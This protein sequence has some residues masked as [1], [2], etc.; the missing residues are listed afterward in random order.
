MFNRFFSRDLIPASFIFVGAIALCYS[1]WGT[2][3]NG[4]WKETWAGFGKTILASGIF[5]SILKLMQISGVFKQELEKLIF[6]PRFLKNRKDIPAYWD[7]ISQEL[8]ENRFPNINKKLLADVKEAYLPIKENIYYDEQEH[9]IEITLNEN[10]KD[11]EVKTTICLTIAG[12]NKNEE[13]NYY[14]F[15]NL[16]FNE[17]PDEVFYSFLNIKVNDRQISPKGV[18]HEHRIEHTENEIINQFNLKLKGSEKYRIER[19]E[20]KKYSLEDNNIIYFIATKLTNSLNVY[21]K[22]SPELK[23]EFLKM[24]TLEDFIMK[25]NHSDFKRFEYKG[26]IY[27]HQ[28]YLIQFKKSIE[29]NS[30]KLRFNNMQAGG[31]INAG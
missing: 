12:A 23:I 22:H 25:Q 26:I 10:G 7:K 19:S 11:L 27:R 29:L 8:C 14:F 2:F 21:I 13:I 9:V 17:A 18:N 4:L 20:I 24:G 1:I 31:D 16:Q 6:E 3:E 30:F 28:G 15:N 5:A